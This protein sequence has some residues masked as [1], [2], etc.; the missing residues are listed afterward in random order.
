MRVDFARVGFAR[1]GFA[2]VDFAHVAIVIV[3]LE[4]SVRQDTK[5]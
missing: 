4:P 2:R 3:E 5:R 1:V